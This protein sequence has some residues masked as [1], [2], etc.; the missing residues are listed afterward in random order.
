ML[1]PMDQPTDAE[2]EAGQ[3]AVTGHMRPE[4]VRAILIAAN[5]VSSV[6]E[7]LDRWREAARLTDE[8][9]AGGPSRAIAW[10]RGWSLYDVAH[11]EFQDECTY[12]VQ[13]PQPSVCRTG[14]RGPEGAEAKS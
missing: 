4:T 2:I 3:A 10:R 14:C 5:A 1:T 13:C 11:P 12:H 7:E 8:Y 6:H 9:I